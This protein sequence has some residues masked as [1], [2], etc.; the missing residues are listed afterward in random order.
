MTALKVLQTAREILSEEKR[1]TKNVLARNILDIKV[2]PIN[3]SAVCFCSMG[4]ICKAAKDLKLHTY[5]DSIEA[6][7]LLTEAAKP[8]MAQMEGIKTIPSSFVQFNDNLRTKHSDIMNLFDEAIKL[9]EKE[10][11]VGN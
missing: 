2:A 1:W 3:P 9:A 4:A 6:E 5:T 8:L 7:N 10:E 11:K